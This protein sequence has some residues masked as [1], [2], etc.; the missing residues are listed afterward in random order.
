MK[1]R[2]LILFSSLLLA[3][4]AQHD[5]QPLELCIGTYG[6]HYYRVTFLPDGTFSKAA[7]IDAVNASFVLPVGIRNPSTHRQCSL[8]HGRWC[9][10][11]ILSI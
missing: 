7:P 8:D 9:S 4:C 5:V 10:M 6:S 1:I 3:G 11:Q 2:Q